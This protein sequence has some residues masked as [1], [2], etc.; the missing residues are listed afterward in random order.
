M[1]SG[2]SRKKEFIYVFNLDYRPSATMAMSTKTKTHIA[3]L[4][5]TKH[6]QINRKPIPPPSAVG[7]T[8]SGVE[9]ND[10]WRRE[11]FVREEIEYSY[12]GHA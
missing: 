7:F 11:P 6:K 9:R 3:K 2:G 4:Q 1:R 5:I 8:H 12:E 10:G